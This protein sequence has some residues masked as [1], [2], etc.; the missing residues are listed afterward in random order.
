MDP[1][2]EGPPRGDASVTIA[3]VLPRSGPP[4]LEQYADLV[5]QGVRLAATRYRSGVVDLVVLDDSG[6]PERD[7]ALVA[8]AE[9]RGAIAIIGPMLSPGIAAAA[10]GR[11]GEAMVLVSPTASELPVH[12]PN[13][14]TLNSVDLRGPRAL[15]EYARRGGLRTAA[16]M[17]PAQEELSRQAWAFRQAFEDGAGFVTTMVPYDAGTTTFAAHIGRMLETAP[18]VV[19]LPLSPQDVQ[20][21]APQLEYYGFD[22][23]GVL[24]MGNEAWTDEQ[25]LREVSTR[26]TDGVIASTP[27]PRLPGETSWDEFV[28]MYEETYR[29]SLD[30]PFP[31]LGYD[32]MRLVL[33]AADAGANT[34]SRIAEGLAATSAYHG[35]TG[36]I[37][38]EGG[39]ITRAPFLYRILDGALTPPPAPELLRPALPDS[40]APLGADAPP[41]T[42]LGTD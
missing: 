27:S 3:V 1:A 28:S 34:T 18:D 33:N 21:V 26:F 36:I 15:A 12:A 22:G 9:R 17:Y 6:L 2:D 37:S 40:L 11:E 13:T 31:A 30:N 8:E 42:P 19:Y 24:L 32:A 25:V 4:Y 20:L 41:A 35:A 5:L 39:E 23:G 38:V 14:Y 7:S 29:R 10:A 16:I